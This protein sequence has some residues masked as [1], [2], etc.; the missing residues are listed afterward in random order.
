MLS[1]NALKYSLV[2]NPSV[3]AGI[4]V[5]SLYFS[6]VLLLLLIFNISWLSLP[7]LILL[8]LVA[9]YGAQKA[10]RKSY[11]L[12]LSDSGVIEVLFANGDLITGKISPSSFY[13]SLF[14]SLHLINSAS[15]FSKKNSLKKK[16]Q[17]RIVIYRDAI[18]EPEYRLLARLINFGQG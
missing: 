8:L 15:D 14:L 16:Y 7:F 1:S 17:S 11:T 9:I 10:C 13:N 2:I 5:F 6:L 4:A 3:Y 18:G 12:K